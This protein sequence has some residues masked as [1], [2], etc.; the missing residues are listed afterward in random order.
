[1]VKCLTPCSVRFSFGTNRINASSL[2]SINP[3][4]LVHYSFCHKNL[5]FFFHYAECYIRLCNGC[6][7]YIASLIGDRMDIEITEWAIDTYLDLVKQSIISK[8]DYKN[9]IR[10]DVELLKPEIGLPFQNPK[11]SNDKFW[12]PATFQ[13]SPIPD[14]FKM[15]W[16]NFGNGNV[17]LRVCIVIFGNRAFICRGYAKTDK[18]EPRE[19]A[20]LK[21]HIRSIILGQYTKRGVI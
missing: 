15:K 10:P 8:P 6:N 16:H 11:F 21:N 9:V 20:K 5:K 18:I 4:I 19:M 12:G 3:F 13:G 7:C 2:L 14:G 17:Q 1:M